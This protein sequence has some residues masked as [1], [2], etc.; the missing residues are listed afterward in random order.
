MHSVH[1]PRSYL[2]V[3]FITPLLEEVFCCSLEVAYQNLIWLNCFWSVNGETST[4]TLTS[5]SSL[6]LRRQDSILSFFSTEHWEQ[7]SL[8]QSILFV[9]KNTLKATETEMFFVHILPW[10]QIHSHQ[11]DAAT[12]LKKYWFQAIWTGQICKISPLG[13]NHGRTSWV[14][15]LMES[16]NKWLTN[17]FIKAYFNHC[18]YCHTLHDTHFLS[19]SWLQIQFQFSPFHFNF[20]SKNQFFNLLQFGP[21]FEM[22]IIP[23][24][25]GVGT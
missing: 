16:M 15:K 6:Q 11:F 20:N 25:W 23:H 19:L 21:Q 24:I 7:S 14:V 4:S 5:K 2:C 17:H 12:R 9:K 8:F 13:I 1:S 22:T 18:H 10:T 3:V